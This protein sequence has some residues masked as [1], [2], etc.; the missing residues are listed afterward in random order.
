MAGKY[1]KAVSTLLK[2]VTGM[3]FMYGHDSAEV[4]TGI[5]KEISYMDGELS[6]NN[7]LK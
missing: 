3:L 1:F 4:V 7:L 2:Q 5:E 6:H